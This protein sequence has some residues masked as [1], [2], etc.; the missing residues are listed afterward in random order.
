MVGKRLQNAEAVSALRIDVQ[1]GGHLVVTQFFVV[2]DTVQGRH[3]LVV[4]CQ[5]DKGT[6]GGGS[7]ML[8]V[9][10]LVQQLA[11]GFLAQEP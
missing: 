2:A 6:R 1:G 5:N 7:Y 11:L 10:I 9:A 4:V 3:R 8:L